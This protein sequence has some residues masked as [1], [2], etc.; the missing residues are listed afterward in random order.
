M[1]YS[2]RIGILIL[3]ILCCLVCLVGILAQYN[4]INQSYPGAKAGNYDT[5]CGSVETNFIRAPASLSF[6]FY[7][8][9]HRCYV[10]LDNA[11]Q[12]EL[13]YK[14]MGWVENKE[15]GGLIKDLRT[16]LFLINKTTLYRVF[17]SSNKGV[18]EINAQIMIFVDIFPK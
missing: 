4:E 9:T 12:V 8:G 7:F 1:R 10:S 13:W 15:D 3:V 6:R 2:P 14:N 16:N 17:F 11:S 18:T 5:S